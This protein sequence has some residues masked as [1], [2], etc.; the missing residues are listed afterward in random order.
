MMCPNC[1]NEYIDPVDICDS[2]GKDFGM[3]GKDANG[4]GCTCVH[5]GEN[6][7]SQCCPACRNELP[8]ELWN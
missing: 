4:D 3:S 2:C 1:G 7:W 8:E 5:C 6:M